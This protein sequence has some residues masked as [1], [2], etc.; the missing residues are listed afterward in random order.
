MNLTEWSECYFSG[1]ALHAHAGTIRF[2][3]VL[4][5]VK[6]SGEKQTFAFADYGFGQQG[7]SVRTGHCS[8]HLIILKQETEP[9]RGAKNCFLICLQGT[10]QNVL[11]YM[12]SFCIFVKF[13]LNIS[14]P[15]R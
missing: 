13:V 9:L 15:L 3:P 2:N 1:L 12:R 4:L 11:P 8:L 7:G 5:F 6:Q 10:K 14:K